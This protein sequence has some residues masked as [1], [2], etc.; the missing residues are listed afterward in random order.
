MNP[1][2]RLAISLDPST[3]PP[4]RSANVN[5][6]WPKFANLPTTTSGASSAQRCAYEIHP[7]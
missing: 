4:L 6:A 3:V 5:R 7:N 2:S 1:E